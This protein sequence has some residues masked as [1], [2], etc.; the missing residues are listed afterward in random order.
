MADK[1]GKDAAQPEGREMD[2]GR[3]LSEALPFMQR[4]DSHERR[5]G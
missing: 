5:W 3:I 4:Y 1:S 2:R